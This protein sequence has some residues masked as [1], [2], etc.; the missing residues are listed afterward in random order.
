M[1]KDSGEPGGSPTEEPV[2]VIHGD[3]RVEAASVLRFRQDL[4]HKQGAML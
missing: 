3:L 4:C 2:K 1:P